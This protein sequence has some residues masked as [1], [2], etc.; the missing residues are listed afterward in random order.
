MNEAGLSPRD[1]PS[2]DRGKPRSNQGQDGGMHRAS[3]A[4]IVHQASV[5]SGKPEVID[6]VGRL[7]RS[8]PI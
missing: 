1:P 5:S 7:E 6:P 4:G 3:G 8:I 2:A